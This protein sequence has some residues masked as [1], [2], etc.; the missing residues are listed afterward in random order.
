M[1]LENI[2]WYLPFCDHFKHLFGP[3]NFRR[4]KKIKYLHIIKIM[5]THFN[6]KFYEI[7]SFTFWQ[8]T[9]NQVYFH[10]YPNSGAANIIPS[11]TSRKLT[12]LPYVS[13][14]WKSKYWGFNA[15][16]CALLSF[17]TETNDFEIC[18]Q[19]G[20]KNVLLYCKNITKQR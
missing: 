20:K 14:N 4:R 9:N 1:R 6:Y 18:E 15:H 5:V 16:T 17:M 8:W 7:M 19:N 10:R 11:Y 12:S 13:Q 2:N 3:L